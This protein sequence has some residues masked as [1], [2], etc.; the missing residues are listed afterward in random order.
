MEPWYVAR[1]LDV[2]EDLVGLRWEIC[3][4]KGR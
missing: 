4:M 3:R 1:V 2:R